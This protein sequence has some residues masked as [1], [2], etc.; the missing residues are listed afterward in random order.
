MPEWRCSRLYQAKNVSRCWAAWVNDPNRSGE[1][2]PVLQRAEVG[3]A[4]GVVV[5]AVRSAVALGDTE[6]SEHE[7]DRFGDHW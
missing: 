7:R 4:V 2:G 1:L 3:F 6:L 5:R